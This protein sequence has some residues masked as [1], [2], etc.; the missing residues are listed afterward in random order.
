MIMTFFRSLIVFVWK[1]HT[2]R[3][4]WFLSFY[5]KKV[6]SRASWITC[7][8]SLET[9]KVH[10]DQE[11]LIYSEKSYQFVSGSLPNGHDPIN[12]IVKRNQLKHWKD[13]IAARRHHIIGFIVMIGLPLSRVI[14][15]KA[16]V[17]ERELTILSTNQFPG[18]KSVH[19][20]DVQHEM[21]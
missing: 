9:C 19:H 6:N 7:F 1:S 2:F 14:D 4:L 18:K 10:K 15:Q 12:A 5:S 8:R 20:A 16:T 13:P 11:K 3:K 17:G 21:Q